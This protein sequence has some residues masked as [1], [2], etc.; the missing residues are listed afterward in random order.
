VRICHLDN[1]DQ[2]AE[3]VA[4]LRGTA[5]AQPHV[6]DRPGQAAAKKNVERR[7]PAG[8]LG[9][10]PSVPP[11]PPPDGELS[12]S[13]ESVL[14]R[15]QLAVEAAKSAAA[16]PPPAPRATRRQQAAEVGERP[17][18]QKALELF[19]VAPGQFR[20]SPPESE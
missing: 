10:I 17:F 16:A 3:L 12:M 4:E 8:S 14:K 19:E 6:A 11:V 7:P 15:Y 2:L 13:E 20:Y 9:A 18:V 5:S 1:L